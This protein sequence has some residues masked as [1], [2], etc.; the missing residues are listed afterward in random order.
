MPTVQA[1]M[2]ICACEMVSGELTKNILHFYDFCVIKSWIYEDN[3]LFLNT[4]WG[5]KTDDLSEENDSVSDKN[6][7]FSV[8]R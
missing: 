5:R 1:T 4:M 2:S 7:M 8:I 6:V 3:E